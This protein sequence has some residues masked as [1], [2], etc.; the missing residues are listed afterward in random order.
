MVAISMDS[1]I[2]NLLKQI[3][4]KLKLIAKNTGAYTPG[5]GLAGGTSYEY[6]VTGKIVDYSDYTKNG[7]NLIQGG[8]RKAIIAGKGL[9]YKPKAQDEIKDGATTYKVVNVR[10]MTEK[11]TVIAYVCQIR[12]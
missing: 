7:N 8:D 6:E 1:Q 4:G 9:H 12:K 5:T 2:L 3:K 11:T 10:E